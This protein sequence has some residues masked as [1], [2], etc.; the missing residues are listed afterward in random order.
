MR[1][2][3]TGASDFIRHLD[4]IHLSISNHVSEIF[5]FFKN[6][7]IGRRYNFNTNNIFLFVFYK[8]NLHMYGSWTFSRGA[9]SYIFYGEFARF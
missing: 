5:H 3:V 6:T 9:K 2:K 4:Y 7:S 8:M 1:L